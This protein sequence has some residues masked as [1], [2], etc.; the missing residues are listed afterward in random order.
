MIRKIEEGFE[1]MEEAC[2]RATTAIKI[3][4]VVIEADPGFGKSQIARQFGEHYFK[5]QVGAAC[6]VVVFTLHAGNLQELSK[7]YLEFAKQLGGDQ[8]SSNTL[9]TICFKN[10]VDQ[11]N[12]LIPVVGE[13]LHAR[14]QE[15]P[16]LQWLIVVDN[17]FNLSDHK[18]ER[19]MLD[20]L[21]H[22]D[23]PSMKFWG[24]GKV[25]ITMQLRGKFKESDMRRIIVQDSLKL[26]VEK[27]TEIL[28]EVAEDDE[29]S[30]P[31][32]VKCIAQKLDCIPLALV[33]AATY[34]NCVMKENAQYTWTKYEEDLETSV[35]V[36]KL[37]S[38]QY[39]QKCLPH[40]VYMTL[41]KLTENNDVVKTAFMAMSYC[42]YRSIPGD[43][44][45]RFLQKQLDC[46]S[47]LSLKIAKLRE[48]PFLTCVDTPTGAD[49]DITLY[50]MHRVTHDILQHDVVPKWGEWLELAESFLLPLLKTCLQHDKALSALPVHSPSRVFFSA[51]VFSV[52]RSASTVYQKAKE[53][54]DERR[55]QSECLWKEI[56]KAMYVAVKNCKL[57]PRSSSE[58]ED[59]LK[60][61]IAITAS[62]EMH[63]Y[64]SR[65]KH[66][67]YLS[68]LCHCL[69]NAGKESEARESGLKALSM[70]KEHKAKPKLIALALQN[71]GWH[72]GSE[73][74][75]G[76]ATI[77]ENLHY[78]E[79]AFTED[80]K[81]YAVSLFQLGEVLKKRDRN[82]GRERLEKSVDILKR[83]GDSIELMEAQS[84]YARFLLKSWSSTDYR[85]ALELCEDNIRMAEKLIDRNTMTYILMML[86]WA[87]AS[88]ACFDPGRA[89]TELPAHLEMVKRYHQRPVQEWGLQVVMATAHLKKGNIDEG[90][91]WL[92]ACT[93][94]QE[95][96]DFNVQLPD[97]IAIS[98]ALTV[99]P[100]VNW[101]VIK[102]VNWAIIKPVNWAVIKPV[103]SVF[104]ILLNL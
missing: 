85:L 70:L 61:C 38:S 22:C 84:Y 99:L 34:K 21:P 83:K 75:L 78:V 93:K 62:D 1:A 9:R 68:L 102:P 44:V 35:K 23:N 33:S 20:F 64:V 13:R 72:F 30:E 50:H 51:H 77:E 54:A 39:K 81:E 89:I 49:K 28:W 36:I 76:I 43:L 3:P 87:R 66:A 37:H 26:S 52:A 5:K 60:E 97:R 27:A 46:E 47:G 45:C 73:V 53:E 98:L 16:G 103:T 79:D 63:A 101:A 14:S 10:S 19:K 90:I 100:I 29:R 55:C 67:K 48:C 71:L 58:Q 88:S 56:P 18:E 12:T 17:L 41:K 95:T 15:H 4:T 40:A 31:D 104:A 24:T 94:L 25:L 91:S 92:R 6:P 69:G 96:L 86:N 32:V 80:S 74:D 59:L 82:K 2:A 57:S 65:V 11:L 42:E 7:S 8:E